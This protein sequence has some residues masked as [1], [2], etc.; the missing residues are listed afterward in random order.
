[1]LSP[2]YK[3]LQKNVDWTWGE[4]QQKAFQEAK[5]A[6]V[7]AEILANYD[8]DERLILQCD[9]SPF[10]IGP[11]NMQRP[12]A[13]TSRSLSPTEKKYAQLDKEA[14]AI[15]FGVRHFHHYWVT[16]SLS[17]QITGHCNICSATH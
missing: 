16:L 11:T 14:L 5:G 7:S 6:L 8:P 4:R 17:N 9:A 10:G 3:L 15:G 13:F 2:L 1:M 12:V